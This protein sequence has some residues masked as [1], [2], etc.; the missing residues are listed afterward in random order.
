MHGFL[1]K[2]LTLVLP[3]HFVG[4]ETLEVILSLDDVLIGIHVCPLLHHVLH[5]VTILLLAC[6][7]AT[8]FLLDLVFLDNSF[9]KFVALL[10]DNADDLLPVLLFLALTQE[11]FLLELVHFGI[12]TYTLARGH[13]PVV[14]VLN[15]NVLI[16][17]HS[18]GRHDN[19]VE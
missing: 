17:E 16:S 19:E 12:L 18:I 2:R 5:S 11:V 7:V 4:Y 13:V 8:N 3:V 6:H 15:K 1:S 10:L 14:L 9:G